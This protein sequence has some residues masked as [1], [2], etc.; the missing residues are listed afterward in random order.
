AAGGEKVRDEIQGAS[1]HL[2]RGIDDHH[3]LA[4]CRRRVGHAAHDR[5]ATAQ[6]FAECRYR[7]AGSDTE[8]DCAAV[9][10]AA[11]GAKDVAD[12]QGLDGDEDR[13]S[14]RLNSSHVKISYAVLCLKKKK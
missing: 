7:G 4:D 11:I 9:A 14:T 1:R 2:R 6:D 10:E 13:K 5:R 3:A 8:K 12:H